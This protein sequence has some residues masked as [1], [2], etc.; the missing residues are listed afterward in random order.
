MAIALDGHQNKS[1]LLKMVL[2]NTSTATLTDFYPAA[3]LGRS[4]SGSDTPANTWVPGALPTNLNFGVSLFT[5][6]DPKSVSGPATGLITLADAGT[7]LDYLFDYSIDGMDIE[8]YRGVSNALFSTYSLVGAYTG[9]DVIADW[10]SKKIRLRDIGWRLNCDL[11]NEF[12]D[13]SGGVDGDS[14]VEGQWKPYLIGQCRNF[15]PKLINAADQ[16]FQMHIRQ[17]SSITAC[18][19]GGVD[20]TFHLNYAN[21][22]DLAAAVIPTGKYGTCT[23]EGLVRPSVD[24]EFSIRVDAIGEGD[25]FLGYPVPSKRA[26]IVRRIATRDGV[27]QLDDSNDLDSTSFG[28]VLTDHPAPLGYYWSERITKIAA[29][30]EV[31]SGILG[32]WYMKQNG[33]LAIG[34]TP[35]LASATSAETI[36]FK[37]YGMSKIDMID[38]L[39]PPAIIQIGWN[40]NYGPETRD[41]LAPAAALDNALAT[42]L[43]KDSDWTTQ[44]GGSSVTAIYPSAPTIKCQGN[45]VNESDAIDEGNRQNFVYGTGRRRWRTTMEIDQ[46]ADLIDRV[47]TVTNVNKVAM[48]SSK[49]V[50]IASVDGSGFGPVTLDFWG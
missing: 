12:Y 5:S 22:S 43:E 44:G 38:F 13:G 39:I 30:Q 20:L 1:L 41:R 3:N 18:R 23:A 46:F 24:L 27:T 36:V 34:Y 2:K 49:K 11:H 21:Y 31:M 7:D 25:S 29:I 28:A 14:N 45:F 33:K 48:G 40:R 15:P 42:S 16:I 32:Y 19:H 47:V 17:V 6:A 50:L 10:D 35:Y 26:E 8:L 4:S 9:K 37:S